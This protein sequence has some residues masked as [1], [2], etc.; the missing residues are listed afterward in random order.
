MEK[1]VWLAGVAE[2]VFALAGELALW[3]SRED[4]WLLTL[5]VLGLGLDV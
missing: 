3:F 1:A 2:V 5:V 4:R